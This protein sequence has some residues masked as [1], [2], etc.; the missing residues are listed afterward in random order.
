MNQPKIWSTIFITQRDH[1]SFIEMCLK[2]SY[3]ALLDVTMGASDI[4]V[5]NQG[6]VCDKDN[7]GR[8]LPSEKIPCEWHFQFESLAEPRHSDRIRSLTIDFDYEGAYAMKGKRVVLGSCR[9]F[10]AS[11]PKL[12]ALRWEDQAGENEYLFSTPPFPP[13]LRSL[14]YVGAWSDILMPVSNLTAF[15]LESGCAIDG[16]SLE[17]IRLFISN[18]R[19]LESLKFQYVHFDDASRGPPVDLPNLKSLDIGLAYDELSTI[20]HVPAFSRLSSLRLSAWPDGCGTTLTAT[21]DNVTFSARCLT[22]EFLITWEGFTGHARPV[23]R[24]ICL[25]DDDLLID[26]RS[27]YH[28][29]FASILSSAHTLEIGKGYFPFWYDRFME[30]LKQLGPQLRTIR[31]AILDDSEVGNGEGQ[32]E[33]SLFLFDRIEELVE[34]RFEHGR[35]L[36]VVERMILGGTE[37]PNRYLDFLWRRFYGTRKLHRFVQPT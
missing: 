36:S 1:R 11:F 32:D 22:G 26:R 18:N 30:D 37:R 9:F 4:V 24:H 2:R 21:G 28:A 5:A 31:F 19:S 12:T 29:E 15:V 7:R 17:A 8:L 25:D 33:N 20:I 34:Y 13:T 35:P 27:D 3:P 6:C 14:T 23:I 16:T 10:T